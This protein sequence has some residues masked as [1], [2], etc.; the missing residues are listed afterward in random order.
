[1]N[2]KIVILLAII[3]IV[4]YISSIEAGVVSFNEND[5]KHVIIRREPSKFFF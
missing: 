4:N 2:F 5:K 3:V 1:M